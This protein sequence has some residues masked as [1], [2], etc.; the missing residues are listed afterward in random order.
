M[1]GVQITDC[2]DVIP[3]C[4]LGNVVADPDGLE[5]LLIRHVIGSTVRLVPAAE[6]IAKSRHPDNRS[7]D[8]HAG[9]PRQCLAP[10]V[11]IR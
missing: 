10:A 6:Q 2:N 9:Y 8:R 7:P 5:D 1:C 11:V 3:R 4:R